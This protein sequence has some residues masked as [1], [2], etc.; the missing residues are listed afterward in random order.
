MLL[1]GS[2]QVFAASG[3]KTHTL[4]HV[5]GGRVLSILEYDRIRYNTTTLQGHFQ[6]DE[7]RL[8]RT[9]REATQDAVLNERRRHRSAVEQNRVLRRVLVLPRARHQHLGAALGVRPLGAEL[10]D[11]RQAAVAAAV[12]AAAVHGLH[13]D[14]V[15]LE[16]LGLVVL[17]GGGHRAFGVLEW[18]GSVHRVQIVQS[19]KLSQHVEGLKVKKLKLIVRGGDVVVDKVH[20]IQVGRVDHVREVLVAGARRTRYRLIVSR[21]R[22][23]LHRFDFHLIKS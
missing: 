10:G 16:C 19:R 13:L 1:A 9:W 12:A 7:A 14:R 8:L 23:W 15:H 5:L 20:W 18:R 22:D 2:R 11:K 17:S 6:F 4:L 3:Q 21:W